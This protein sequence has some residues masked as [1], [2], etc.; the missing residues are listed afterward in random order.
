M[1]LTAETLLQQV[2]QLQL[3]RQNRAQ[4]I[5]RTLC[6]PNHPL[7]TGAEWQTYADSVQFT[8]SE[9]YGAKIIYCKI[10]GE[11]TTTALVS[12]NITYGS[13]EII[14][15][16]FTQGLVSESGVLD[17]TNVNFKTS[18]YVSV[19]EGDVINVA[20]P[21]NAECYL[22][23]W[24]NETLVGRSL[25]IEGMHIGIMNNCNKIAVC[26]GVTSSV[27]EVTALN[28]SE[29]A[30]T[31]VVKLNCWEGNPVYMGYHAFDTG[32]WVENLSASSNSAG[33]YCY[34]G[35]S[36]IGKS[37]AVIEVGDLG[38]SAYFRFVKFLDV[39]YKSYG[40]IYNKTSLYVNDLSI[41]NIAINLRL[42]TSKPTSS[43]SSCTL[44]QIRDAVITLT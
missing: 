3:F 18:S 14:E 36:T 8:L 33:W 5:Q 7:F 2:I 26:V 44:A 39:A 34:R 31:T 4:K 24:D 12:A 41:N 20:L 38:T 23:K 6:C 27:T 16:T 10:K 42:S 37:G 29:V 1:Q 13:R 17:S 11:D 19:A 30:N 25:I 35:I 43:Q 32:D 40:Y 9:G 15:L 22:L 21:V 28:S